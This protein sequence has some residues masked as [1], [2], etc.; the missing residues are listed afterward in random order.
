MGRHHI[1]CH[2]QAEEIRPQCLRALL[3]PPRHRKA[4]GSAVTL[5]NGGAVTDDLEGGSRNAAVPY[6][7]S[8]RRVGKASCTSWMVCLLRFKP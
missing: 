1:S 6:W 2:Q 5:A 7:H 8:F 3:P 4:E